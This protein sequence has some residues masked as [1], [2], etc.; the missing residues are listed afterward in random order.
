MGAKRP[1]SL[2]I[3]YYYNNTFDFYTFF[4]IIIYYYNNKFDFYT[5]VHLK[6]YYIERKRRYDT[7]SNK[8]N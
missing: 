2:V 7:L 4:L 5:F 8:L 1:K 3:I 6:I